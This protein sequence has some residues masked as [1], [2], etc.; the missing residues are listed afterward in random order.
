[1]ATGNNQETKY[2]ADITPQSSIEIQD[3]LMRDWLLGM[4]FRNQTPRVVASWQS[5]QF[6]AKKEL[7]SD[8]TQK[9]AMTYPV[10]SLSVGTITPDLERRQVNDVRQGPDGGFFATDETTSDRVLIP[11]PIPILIPYQLDIVAKVRRDLR[12]LETMII[13]RFSFTDELLL[14][15]QFPKDR[16]Y[17]PSTGL[18]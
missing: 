14:E 11:W 6:S 17:I 13:E 3:L 1:M 5:K 7:D 18:G 8:K 4:E 9:T 16:G 10:L 12:Y 2:F 15:R